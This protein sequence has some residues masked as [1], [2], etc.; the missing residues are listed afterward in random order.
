MASNPRRNAPAFRQSDKPAVTEQSFPARFIDCMTAYKQGAALK[1]GIELDLFTVLAEGSQTAES[2][3]LRLQASIRGVRI[4]S[5]YLTIEGFLLKEDGK[6]SVTQDV[7]MFLN[8]KSPAYIGSAAFFLGNTVLMEN[9]RDLAGCVRKGGTVNAEGTLKPENPVWVEFARS[10]AP[11]AAMDAEFVATLLSADTMRRCKVLDIAAGHGMYGIALGRHN[12]NAEIVAIDWKNVLAVAK[13]NAGKAGISSRY[14]T[15]EG[16]AFEVDFGEGY[17]IVLLTGFLHH[18][19]KEMNEA[20]LRKV[21]RAL[22]PGGRAVVLEFIPNDDR[23]TPRIPAEFSLT[24]L[25][26]T[27]E[28]DAYTYPG[29]ERMFRNAGFRSAELHE[30]P[31]SPQRVVIGSK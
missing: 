13:E 14:H 6:Y 7:A 16:S 26:S 25:A 17:D 28:G 27:P 29:F 21:H 5:D 18:F 10:M 19:S 4:I 24:M 3:A 1:G 15:I 11:L 30:I 22:Q 2:L 9:F 8:R 23:L 31:P 20:L 12:P